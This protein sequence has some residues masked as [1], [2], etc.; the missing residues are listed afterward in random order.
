MAESD[1]ERIADLESVLQHDDPR[2]ARGLGKGHPRR[3][4]EYRRGRAW[5]AMI[6]AVA[7]VVTGATMPH[8]LLLAAGLVMAALAVNLF[9]STRRRPLRLRRLRWRGLRRPKP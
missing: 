9:D 7:A 6:L 3:P 1:D 8:G 4:R 5:L 2:F